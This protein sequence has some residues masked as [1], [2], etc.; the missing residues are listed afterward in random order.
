MPKMS[1]GEALAKSLVREGVEVMFGIGGIHTSGILA[2]IRD[3]P[4][5]SLITTRHEQGAAHMADGYA[6]ASG[7][8]GVVLVVPGPA[9]YNAASGLCTAYAR[10]VPVLA[11]AAQ[12]PRDQIGKD[13]GNVHEVL[14]QAEIVR[15]VTK[16]RRQALSPREIPD[17]VCEAFRQMRTGRARPVLI[18][19]PPEAGVER[20][21]VELRSPARF[22][23]I[24]PSR[25]DLREAARVI[26]Q[27]RLP[28]IYAGGGVARSDAEE[29]LVHLAEATN[30]PVITSAGGKGTISD[31][32]PLSYGSCV[33]PGGERHEMNQLFEVMQ[34]A[35]VVIGIGARFSMGNPAGDSSTI[36]NINIDDAELTRVQSNTI[37]LHG[38][39]RATIEAMLPILIGAGAGDRPSPVEAVTAARDLIAYYDIRDKEPQYAIM[40]AIKRSVPEDTFIVWGVSQFGYYARTHYQVDHP[41]TYIDSGYSF[42][43]GFAFPTALGAKVAAPDRPVVCV[44]GDGGFMFNSSEL[45][46]A[47]NYDINATTIVFRD[48]AYGNVARDMEDFFDGTYETDLHNPD[49]VKFAESFGAVGMR[50]DDPMDLETLLPTALAHDAPV[51]IDVPVRH[52]TLP[53][54]KLQAHLPSIAWTQPQEGLIPS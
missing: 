22:S 32:H 9:L 35:D 25:E 23:R 13:A 3:E 26:G 12:V 2:G 34:S 16:W 21:T 40:E 5:L 33:S 27:S 29:A 37:P 48:D 44:S 45:S 28:V 47:V 49:L 31:R 42:N 4:G 50:T 36:V 38:D 20:D 7:K 46:T 17:A 43:L 1:G 18:E 39:A 24:V 53:R 19:I 14:D 6:R 52:M 11:I 54:A 10:S 30:I 15:P 51:I 41:K 8:P